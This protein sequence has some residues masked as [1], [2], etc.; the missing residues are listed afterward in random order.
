MEINIKTLTDICIEKPIDDF[1]KRTIVYFLIS[2]GE[3]DDWYNNKPVSYIKC[4][5]T[6][7][8]KSEEPYAAIHRRAI[9]TGYPT[10]TYIAD[11]ILFDA[12]K[13]NVDKKVHQILKDYADS[14]NIDV[15]FSKYL[16]KN[17]KFDNRMYLRT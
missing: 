7:L 10:P 3:I 15:S 17:A 16:N 13:I 11:Y 1:D 8:Y 12:C 5:Q 9:H 14:K 6:T 4:G 2:V